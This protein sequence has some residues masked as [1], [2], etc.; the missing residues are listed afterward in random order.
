[1]D[2]TETSSGEDLEVRDPE[3]RDPEPD[4][5]ARV[6]AEPIRPTVYGNTLGAEPAPPRPPK[7]P[8]RIFIYVFVFACLVALSLVL[9]SS[10]R[11]VKTTN[12]AATP[13]GNVLL[14]GKTASAPAAGG[15]IIDT[16][17]AKTACNRSDVLQK[18]FTLV[19]GFTTTAGTAAAWEDAL[20]QGSQ[21]SPL[22]ELPPDMKVAVCYIDGPWQPPSNVA[23]V[24][25][26][27]GVVAD[28]AI[29]VVPQTGAVVTAPIA[30]HDSLPILQPASPAAS[31]HS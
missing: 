12:P 25:R 26:S 11:S 21:T 5:D 6:K 3:V 4:L 18:G 16:D 27:M 8:W 17:F 7:S 20:A 29:S 2:D 13:S 23:D 10:N 14:P 22:H 19:A 1:M 24:Y 9:R 30:P 15:P 28:R 31:P